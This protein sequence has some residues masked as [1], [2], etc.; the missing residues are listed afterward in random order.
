[1][2]P[3]FRMTLTVNSEPYQ[4]KKNTKIHKKKKKAGLGRKTVEKEKCVCKSQ[5]DIVNRIKR[6]TVYLD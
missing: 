3:L 2:S 6:E 1:M 4:K 5:I